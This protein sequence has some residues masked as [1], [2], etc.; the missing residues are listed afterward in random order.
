MIRTSLA[1]LVLA[2]TLAFAP[3]APAQSPA[4]CHR[5]AVAVPF[6]ELSW[7]W[8]WDGF[9]KFWRSQLGKTTGITGTV[10]LVV[11]VGVLIVMSAKKS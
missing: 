3:P 9:R 5:T 1:A 6:G 10:A 4:A 11:L 8:D 7:N 2:A